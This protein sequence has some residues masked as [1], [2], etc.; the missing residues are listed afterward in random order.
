MGVTKP[1]VSYAMKQLREGGYIT[2]ADDSLIALTE[3]GRAVAGRMLERH[4]TLARFLLSLG[5]SE[6][7]AIE[8]AC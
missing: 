2:M 3:S 4:M 1:S 7:A 8:D 5:V 6:Q